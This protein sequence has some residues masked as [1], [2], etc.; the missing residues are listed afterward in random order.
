MLYSQ[1]GL[2]FGTYD[3]K[4]GSFMNSRT[5]YEISA[6]KC[7]FVPVISYN[8]CFF[9]CQPPAFP[10]ETP[11]SIKEFIEEKYLLPRLDADEFSPEKVG[12]QWDFDW[13]DRADVHLE[14]S[15]PRSVVVPTWE[16]PF[17]RQKNV[18]VQGKWDPNSVQVED[19]SSHLMFVHIDPTI[20][21][22]EVDI[23]CI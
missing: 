11:E 19:I 18:S 20:T 8:S 12:R 13:F 3:L 2:Y 1:H 15:L 6:A 9:L 4:M 10:T 23:M 5:V 21:I 14:P 17:R 22:Q 7:L 16:L